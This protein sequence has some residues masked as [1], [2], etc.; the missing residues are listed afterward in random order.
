MK[1]KGLMIGSA[2]AFGIFFTGCTISTNSLSDEG[3]VTT[4]CTKSYVTPQ[5]TR[6]YVRTRC[7]PKNYAENCVQAQ[8]SQKYVNSRCQD[9]CG[10]SL[11]REIANKKKKLAFLRSTPVK[12]F[13]V[14]GEGVAPQNTI[15]PAQALALAKRAAIADAYRQLGGKL[16][17]VKINATDTVKDAAIKDSRIISQVDALVKDAHVMDTSYKD[18]LY[19]VKMQLKIDGNTWQRIFSY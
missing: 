5:C 1:I 16:Y 11:D 3:C 15:S 9:G 6:K 18:G 8:C 12:E 17:G 19:R 10:N 7:A 13:I 14:T 2:V 4:G